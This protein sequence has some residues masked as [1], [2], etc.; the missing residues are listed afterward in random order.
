VDWNH[1]QQ[2]A[3]TTAIFPLDR[4]LEYTVLGLSS[5]SG[6]LGTAY[7]NEKLKPFGNITTYVDEVLS[8]AGDLCWYGA[9]VADAIDLPFG[10][11]RAFDEG[12]IENTPG[13]GR[14]FTI[15][16]IQ[17]YVSNIAS[18]VKKAIRDNEGFVELSH[19]QAIATELKLMMWQLEK[20]VKHYDS[21]LDAVMSKNLNK[22]ADRKKRGVLSG[23]GDLR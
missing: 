8:E 13:L 9:A 22:L 14:G 16:L 17:R 18:I 20:L 5:E 4:S 7:L 11:V 3:L 23:S 1:Y 15:L 6:E 21:T 12:V 2:Q 10:Q 19:R